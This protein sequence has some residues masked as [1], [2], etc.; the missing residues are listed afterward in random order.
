MFL[1]KENFFHQSVKKKFEFFF[2]IFY[3]ELDLIYY[4][5]YFVFSTSMNTKLR[6]SS[7]MPYESTL[8][9]SQKSDIQ[10]FSSGRKVY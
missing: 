4:F 7:P 3:F 5:Y 8:P 6:E 9:D 2:L 10:S 1:A